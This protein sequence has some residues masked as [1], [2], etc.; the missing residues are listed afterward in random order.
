MAVPQQMKSCDKMFLILKLERR[1]WQ[2]CSLAVK[3]QLKTVTS[4]WRLWK[5]TRVESPSCCGGCAGML[6]T[7]SEAQRNCWCL[8]C[9]ALLG[10]AGGVGFRQGLGVQT[11]LQE[12]A[13]VDKQLAALPSRFAVLSL[14]LFYKFLIVCIP[15]LKDRLHRH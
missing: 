1:C 8:H 11:A 12:E 9:R 15:A 4:A 2:L 7:S 14:R 6:V 13:E 10:G 5:R 3:W